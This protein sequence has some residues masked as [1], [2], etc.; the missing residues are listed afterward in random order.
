M[1][2]IIQVSIPQRI[3]MA[4]HFFI[5]EELLTTTDYVNLFWRDAQQL[6]VSYYHLRTLGDSFDQHGMKNSSTFVKIYT[7]K[8]INNKI[9]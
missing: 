8:E 5:Q 3:K 2:G 9:K 6:E 1:T 7:A 4:K